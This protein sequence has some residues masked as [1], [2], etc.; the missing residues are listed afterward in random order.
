MNSWL[1]FAPAG[2]LGSGSVV[3][4]PYACAVSLPSL[5]AP[6]VAVQGTGVAAA[7]HTTGAAACLRATGLFAIGAPVTSQPD[8]ISQNDGTT[9]GF[10]PS[11]RPQS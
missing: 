2:V 5:D 1:A 3:A 9:L 7:G 10:H 4:R 11:G 8:Q 6:V